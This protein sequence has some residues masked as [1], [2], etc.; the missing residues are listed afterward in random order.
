MGVAFSAGLILTMALG[1]GAPSTAPQAVL[2]EARKIAGGL[3]TR[4]ERS[5]A[6]LVLAQAQAKT[7]DRKG[8]AGSLRL[9]WTAYE[10]GSDKGLSAGDQF[11]WPT[12]FDEGDL[13]TLPVEYAFQFVVAGDTGA[14]RRA[15]MS[16]GA[17]SLADS[18]RQGL[19][20]RLRGSYPAAIETVT[21]TTAQQGRR[22][23]RRRQILEGIQ[24][25]RKE[26]DAAKYSFGLYEASG[27]LERMND[28]PIALQLMREAAEISQRIE[29]PEWRVINDAQIAEGLWRLDAKV[30]AK[31]L[32]AQ[33]EKG[34]VDLAAGEEQRRARFT[35]EQTK[36][37]M[38][39]PNELEAVISESE[40]KP[41]A[42]DTG[43]PPSENPNS[44]YTL[45]TEAD[46]LRSKGDVAAAK[47]TL[48][49]IKVGPRD[50]PWVHVLA[51]EM[52]TELGDREAARAN[53]TLGSRRNLARLQPQPYLDREA[54]H[55]LERIAAAQN[56]VGDKVGA[57]TTLTE[58]I[59]RMA[60][61]KRWI[62]LPHMGEGGGRPV[63]HDRQSPLLHAGAVALAR[64]G[65]YT[66]AVETARTIPSPVHRAIT[67]AVTVRDGFPPGSYRRPE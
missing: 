35:I 9:G 1:Q 30:E 52:Q 26:K 67:L 61:T 22:A 16:L 19:G 37:S 12:L 23:A 6:F 58:G 11:D 38:G 49:R 42:P 60:G 31:T 4:T 15:A 50:D 17:S 5:V 40:P 45:L 53:L 44:V 55:N 2:A 46:R 20:Q 33:A 10:K 51:G 24:E 25:V 27:E 13:S 64:A 56:A 39:M 3:S 14:A 59:R 34:L 29:N 43:A 8:A 65:F 36:R 32:L 47:R 28:R 21:L 7:G 41:A 57:Q 54:M 66:R 63:R 48:R 18:Y 62:T